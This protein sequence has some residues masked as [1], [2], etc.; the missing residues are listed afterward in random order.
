MKQ[1]FKS[2]RKKEKKR[3]M[4]SIFMV[5][6]LLCSVFT[7]V[8][9][10]FHVKR[11]T[12]VQAAET[13]VTLDPSVDTVLNAV[14][15]Y[16]LRI[17]TNPD[18]SS[19]WN[20]IGL[21]RS[22]LYVPSSYVDTFYKNVYAYLVEKKW[23]LT[24]TKYSD[25]SKLIV[26]LTAIGKDAQNIDG[27]NLLA[28]LSD[29]TDVK[30]QGFNGP[31]WALIAL[32][33]HPSY[34]IP[35]D[36]SAEEQTTEE[37]LISYILGKETVYGGWT[38]VGTEPDADITGM[39]IQ[40]LSPYYGK[41]ADVT[42]AID[43]ALNWL[44]ES[45]LPSGGYGTMGVETSESAAQI[46]VALC[47]LGIDSAKDSR[48]I[49][50]GKSPMTGLFQYYLPEGG[51]MHVAAGAVNNGGGDAGMLNGMATEQGMYATVAY[52]RLLE[53]KTYL[54]DMSDITLTTGQAVDISDM[55]NK[56]KGEETSL[57]PET[58]GIN[59]VGEISK[60]SFR[61]KNV[62]VSNIHLDYSQISVEKGK[63]RK[64]TATVQPSN[65]SNKK[66]R[67]ISTDKKVATVTKHGKV[68]G[69]REGVAEIKVK[70]KDGSRVKAF[71][72]VKVYAAGDIVTVRRKSTIPSAP[73]SQI[74]NS[75]SK[76][77]AMGT[78]G[79]DVSSSGQGTDTKTNTAAIST[80]TTQSSRKKEKSGGW[81]FDGAAYMPESSG[82]TEDDDTGNFT[83]KDVG[84][85]NQNTK[86]ERTITIEIPISVFYVLMGAGALGG[87]EAV[88][89]VFRKKGL[90]GTVC[91]LIHKI[92]R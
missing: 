66:L 4:V 63:T 80:Q 83:M 49:K 16:M 31:I 81:S 30:R 28:Y 74:R 40:A 59:V 26:G 46:V 5:Y 77:G 90:T 42:G 78:S 14:R 25:Y 45:Q 84:G 70:A 17:D 76:T 51:F 52:K 89:F 62:K 50:N 85:S 33:S 7:S 55:V 61:K 38:L 22:G 48:F 75:T 3:A 88:F 34:K 10:G 35:I 1:W 79:R 21:T 47:S 72:V 27:H 67:W 12:Q 54:Y 56:E 37:G 39:A 65:A 32:K 92:R 73:K 15:S 36:S 43:R 71:C 18:Y 82:I 9:T 24:R 64:L 11:V 19:I 57:M 69:V 23:I 41:R 2:I 91:N 20:V 44:S 58:S 68:T 53:K 29:F 60:K 87:L 86:A 8:F 6:L 13:A